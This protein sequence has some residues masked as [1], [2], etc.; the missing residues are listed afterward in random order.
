[1]EVFDQGEYEHRAVIEVTNDRLDLG[2]SE[3]CSG[4]NTPLAGDEFICIAAATDTNR[5]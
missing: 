4:S 5:L 3:V 2:P 1:L